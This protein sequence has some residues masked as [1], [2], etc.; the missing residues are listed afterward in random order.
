[1]EVEKREAEKKKTNV[2]DAMKDVPNLDQHIKFKVV[3]LIYSLGMKDV[4][5]D[6]SVEERY[7]WIQSNI[8]TQ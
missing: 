2:W 6:M 1:M 5:A 3:T 4:F 7:G 8:N